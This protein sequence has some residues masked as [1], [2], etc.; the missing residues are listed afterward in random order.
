M[1]IQDQCSVLLDS[2]CF[3][4]IV[5]TFSDS[6]AVIALQVQVNRQTCL[7]SII[8]ICI[9]VALQPQCGMLF[10]N[11]NGGGKGPLHS[12]QCKVCEDQLL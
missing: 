6:N 2:S 10:T 7:N 1:Q 9:A 8:N 11:V 4:L 12:Q 5:A 3:L